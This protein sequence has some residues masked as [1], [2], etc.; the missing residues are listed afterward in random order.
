MTQH[1]RKQWLWR[2]GG[3]GALVAVATLTFYVGRDVGASKE[4]EVT[5]RGLIQALDGR[6]VKRL[7]EMD[8]RLQRIEDMLRG[9]TG[10]E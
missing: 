5:N 3:V 9:E 4:R 7:D 2:V 10:E 6:V 8:S 1:A